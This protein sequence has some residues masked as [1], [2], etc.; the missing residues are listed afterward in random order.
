MSVTR[1]ASRYAKSL[2]D[3]S[4]SQDKLE[5]I[6]DDIHTFRKAVEHRELRLL[7]ASPIIKGDKKK[8][9][10]NEIFKG[11]LDDLTMKFMDI[12]VSKG[13]ERYLKAIT[14]E[15]I[16]QY[17]QHK[18]I[19]SVVITTADELSNEA[20]D[21]IK[22]KLDSSK[23]TDDVIEIKTKVDPELIGGFIIEFEDNLYDASV[24]HKLDRLKKE[25]DTNLY[26][27]RF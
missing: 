5:T 16:L 18:H 24:A 22:S 17:K 20:L 13:R 4:I 27:K 26:E 14:D 21:V 25:F 2:I 7:L 11:K 10:L 12:T 15:F 19:S 6:L 8:S 23:T 1:I 9:I 3:L